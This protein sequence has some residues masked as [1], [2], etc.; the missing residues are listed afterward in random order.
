MLIGILYFVFLGKVILRN[1]KNSVFRRED[2]PVRHS[3]SII[4]PFRNEARHLRALITHINRLNYPVDR[5]EVIFVDDFSNDG[6]VEI[7]SEAEKKFKFTLVQS[8]P[9]DVPGKKNALL[10]GIATAQF[11]RII[12]WDA[13]IRTAPDYLRIFNDFL[14]RNPGNKLLAAPVIIEKTVSVVERV[15]QLEFLALQALTEYGFSVNK[16]FLSNGANLS[17][18]KKAFY[19]AG[20]YE[21]NMH[22][23]GGDDIFLVEKFK[24]TFP[25]NCAYLKNKDAIVETRAMPG[26]KEMVNQRLRWGKKTLGTQWNRGKL[27]FLLQSLSYAEAL[28]LLV[29]SWGHPGV[30]V[31]FFL[32]SVFLVSGHYYLLKQ[33]AGHYGTRFGLMDFSAAQIL[34]PAIYFIVAI[35]VLTGAK[36]T[37]KDRQYAR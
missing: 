15:Q 36:I 21:G 32:W 1:R 2:V 19:E 18:D 13:D 27:F 26:L 33:T 7:I 23:A 31:L 35:K 37:W 34:L 14:T 30:W 20:A 9:A 8:E 16:P 28:I 4:I 25:G 24:A 10:R 3:F 6:S 29:C 5:F 22:F 11:D 12:T 17:F